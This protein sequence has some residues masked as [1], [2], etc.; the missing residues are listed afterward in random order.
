MDELQRENQKLSRQL[1]RLQTTLERNKAIAASLASVNAMRSIEKERQ[2]AYMQLLLENSPDIIILLDENGRY[3]YCTSAFLE[4]AHIAGF[5]SI[6]GKLF[7]E[8]FDNFAE[9]SWVFA[10]GERMK[11]CM[12]TG[13][14]LQLEVVLDISGGEDRIYSLH[15]KPMRPGEHG[16]ESSVMMLHDITDI[17]SAQEQAEQA[18]RAAE[19]ASTAKSSFL[20]NMSHEMRTPMNA[21]IGMTAIGKG[22]ADIDRKNYCLDKIEDASTHLL[23]VI[24]DILDMSKIEANKFELSNTDFLFEKMLQKVVNV[25]NFRMEEK[26]LHFT[27]H[28]DDAIPRALVG[29]DQRLAQVVTNLLS[30]AV[31]FTPEGGAIRLDTALVSRG[32]GACVLQVSVTDTGIGVSEEQKSRLFT[33]FE[34]ADSGIARKFGGTGLGLAISKSIVELMDGKIWIDS[35]LGQGSTFTFTVRLE[36]GAAAERRSLLAPGSNLENLRV[37]AVDDSPDILEYFGELAHSF[38]IHCDTAPSGREA[39]AKI[40]E[41]GGYDVYFIDWKMP[42]MDGIELS[43]AVKARGAGK[44]VVIMISAA[45]WSLIEE[46]AKRAGVDKFLAKPLFP[47]LIADCINE[48]LGVAAA[49]TATG[50]EGELDI[51]KDY[52]ILLAEDVE[53]NREIVLALLEPTAIQINCAENG[54]EAVALFSASQDDYDL[55]LMDM[56]MPE[57]DGCGATRKIRALGTPKALSVPIVAMTANVF[58]E[59]IEKCLDAGMDDHIGKPIDLDEVLGK[60]SRYLFRQA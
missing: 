40:E 20:S 34:Q 57:M 45:E 37:L 10:L 8:V 47:S 18:R 58:R 14:S 48:C 36:I 27:V 56:Q 39:L 29:D 12:Q 33:S 55:I 7:G 52:K 25:I 4:K 30:N 2:E 53:I 49:V 42:E 9:Q 3:A 35:E 24:N 46:E 22:S 11:G 19:T 15:F 17:R 28:I 32:E 51:F 26:H 60:L 43:R 54:S 59:D 13:S 6:S 38:G 1:N 44:N 5:G 41:N 31:K 21:I 50:R 16:F 23:G